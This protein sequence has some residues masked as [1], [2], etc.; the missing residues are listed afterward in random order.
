[1]LALNSDSRNISISQAVV[2]LE[3]G[4]LPPVADPMLIENGLLFFRAK[5]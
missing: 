2:L 5:C 3:P 1:M 4:I